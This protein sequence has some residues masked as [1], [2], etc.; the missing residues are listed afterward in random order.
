M[1]LTQPQARDARTAGVARA[2]AAHQNSWW[3]D[4]KSPSRE[5]WRVQFN[6]SNEGCCAYGESEMTIDDGGSTADAL[7]A[8]HGRNLG[9]HS[10]LDPDQLLDGV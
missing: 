10:W 3:S 5:R 2:A 9:R 1:R 7:L 8:E 6:T 4:K